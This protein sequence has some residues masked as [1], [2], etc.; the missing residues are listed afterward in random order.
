M[1]KRYN[2]I[3]AA[4]TDPSWKW[5][6]IKR[7]YKGAAGFAKPDKGKFWAPEPTTK[8]KLVIYL[9]EVAHLTSKHTNPDHPVQCFIDEYEATKLS[10]QWL[11]DAGI[12]IGRDLLKGEKAGL[13]FHW[14]QATIRSSD[15]EFDALDTDP[16]FEEA[17]EFCFT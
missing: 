5:V 3:A 4:H 15:E 7:R 6:R 11:R 13:G 8:A 10:L 2:A 1:N 14:M 17:Q 9:H 16:K 12:P